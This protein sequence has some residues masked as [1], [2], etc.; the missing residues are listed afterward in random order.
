MRGVL[1]ISLEKKR[2]E[3]RKGQPQLA[4]GVYRVGSVWAFKHSA[5]S[6]LDVGYL[7]EGHALER[8][9]LCNWGNPW[10]F[11]HWRLS[12]DNSPATGEE[13]AS[14]EGN[15]RGR[16]D[17]PLHLWILHFMQTLHKGYHFREAFLTTLYKISSPFLGFKQDPSLCFPLLIYSCKCI[18]FAYSPDPHIHHTC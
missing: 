3:A 5:W 9:A 14:L 10:K 2:K 7:E 11:W 13:S 4:L 8:P 15:I 12:G 18:F 6:S 16:E 17:T 1:G